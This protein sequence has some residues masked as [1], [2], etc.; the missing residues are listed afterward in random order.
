MSPPVGTCFPS[1]HRLD[2]STDDSLHRLHLDFLQTFFLIGHKSVRWMN[3]L[4]CWNVVWFL[5]LNKWVMVSEETRCRENGFNATCSRSMDGSLQREGCT[6]ILQAKALPWC[7]YLTVRGAMG[8][9]FFHH[10]FRMGLRSR[11]H[12]ELTCRKGLST[13]TNIE[14]QRVD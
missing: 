2:L 5:K 4:W 9:Q 10:L 7:M 6:Q 13:W 12:K 8:A 11:R 3:P 1:L 14:Q